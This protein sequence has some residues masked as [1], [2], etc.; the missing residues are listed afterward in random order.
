MMDIT[1]IVATY[2]QE[3]TIGRTIDSI[4]SQ[5][6]DAAYE[7][8]VVDDCSTDNTSAVCR[9]YADQYP[10]KVRYI[11][12]QHNLGLVANYIDAI[13]R[14]KGRYIAD[15]A[16]DDFWIDPTKLQ[17][18]FEVLEQNNDI[19]LV[20]TAWQY[21]DPS[22][23]T[24]RPAPDE[25]GRFPQY[26][27]R[28]TAG[29]TLIPAI[30]SHKISPLVHLC[31]SLYRRDIIV[32]AIEQHP[33]LYLSPWLTCEDVQIVAEL[34]S[35]GNFCYLPEV[36]LN[37]TY[38]IDSIS[39]PSQPDKAFRY[40]AGV[41]RLTRLL[42]QLYEIPQ[43][44]LV[45][46]YRKEEAFLAKMMFNAHSKELREQAREL[47]GSAFRLTDPHVMLSVNPLLWSMALTIKKTI[48]RILS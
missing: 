6:T 32:R 34:A 8:L 18:Q 22:A 39:K 25:A 45:S 31:T 16:G 28:A 13:R 40:H 30:V 37:Y 2:N 27:G 23:Q 48:K 26:F 14:A 47:L 29:T 3:D 38:A 41:L 19:T 9:S 21:F 24:V 46:F 7:I 5:K 17:R 1:V 15:C 12:R 44:H 35:K 20:H 33:E 11:R 4:L 42:Q 43:T 36:T 10:D